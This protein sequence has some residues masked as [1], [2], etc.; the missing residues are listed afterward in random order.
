[1]SISYI[2][3]KITISALAI[4]FIS[5]FNQGAFA[6]SYFKKDYPNV[7]QRATDYTLEVAEAMPDTHWS[8]KPTEESMTFQ[9]QLAHLVQ[10]LSFLSGTITGNR[11]DFFKGKD[12]KTL[13]KQELTPILKE[14]FNHVGSL[15][16]S[17]DDQ[18]L[19]ESI[20]FG[21][22]SMPKEN[23]FYLMRD[24]ASHHRGQAILYLRMKGVVAPKYR[25]W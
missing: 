21:G 20:E 9:E 14:A 15:I 6:Q 10:N 2:P 19:R 11:P 1:M 4:L 5:F 18:T 25:G 24:H 16:V 17:V 3:M 13:N 7:W 12:P 8:F 22:V 23:I